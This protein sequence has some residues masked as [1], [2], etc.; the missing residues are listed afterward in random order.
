MHSRPLRVVGLTGSLILAVGCGGGS[1]SAGAGFTAST[2]RVEIAGHVSQR[3]TRGSILV[4]AYTDL[5]PAD[6]PAAHEPASVGTLAPDGA[7]DVEVSA[8]AS[9]TLVFLADG[10]ND[11][12]VD[13]GDPIAVL[14]SPELVDLQA[15]D[16]VEVSDAKIDFIGHR[17]DATVDVT[18]APGSPRPRPT[19]DPAG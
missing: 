9:V 4:F 19:P 11:G 13:Q 12:V 18:R 10:S 1:H 7:F 3:G 17:V 5:G 6:E 2:A 16:R 15:G 8:V 14:R